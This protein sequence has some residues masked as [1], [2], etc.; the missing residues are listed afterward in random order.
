M[1]RLSIAR[2]AARSA[3]YHWRAHAFTAAAAAVAAAVVTGAL[4]VGDSVRG[5]LADRVLERLGSVEQVL[6]ASGFFREALPGEVAAGA[7][8]AIVLR[9]SAEHAATGSRAS[10]VNV[11]GVPRQFWS[12]WGAPGPPPGLAESWGGRK[13]A[14][15]ERLAAALGAREGDAVL[16]HVR[17]GD[18]VPAEH[19][20]GRRTG[21]VRALR[22]DLERVLPGEGLALFDLRHEQA[23]PR[24]VFVPLDVLQRALEKEGLVNAG[25]FGSSGAPDLLGAEM[26][27]SERL[28]VA[29]RRA[30][31]LED[32]GLKL[33]V[34][35]ERGH[36]SLESR[37]LVLAPP[38][39]EA[40]RGAAREAGLEGR[41]VL[42][43]LANTIAAADRQVPYSTIAAVESIAGRRIEPGTIVLTDW[44]AQDLAAKPGDPV[45]VAYYAVGPEH[46]LEER[47]ALF[48][49]A[50]PVPIEGEAADPGW[51]PEYPGI[52]DARSLR[53]W[54]PPFPMDLG[55]IRDRDEDYW[56]A[57]RTTP[58]AFV[59]LEDGRRLWSS[60]FGDLTAV[61]VR[62]LDPAVPLAE[63]ARA[64]EAALLRA[65]G[66]GAAGLAFQAVKAQGLE[67]ARGSTD[68]GALFLGFS[69]F[70]IASALTILS[71]VFRLACARRSKELGLLAAV[72][73][74][75][76][77][78]RG[79]LLLEGGL[80]VACGS[81]LGAVGG[82][83]YA[84]A[85]VAGL[86]GLWR[87]A[88]SAPFL[89]LHA[90]PGS[91]AAGAAATAA[92]GLLTVLAAARRAS[93]EAPRA[94]LARGG[95]DPG[96]GLRSRPRGT[97]ALAAAAACAAL[98][99]ALLAAGSLPRGL[100]QAPAF[101]G[102]GA[103]LLAAALALAKAWLE[104]PARPLRRGL[105]ALVRLGASYGRRAPG[106]SFA[107]VLLVA[108][109]SFVLVTVAASRRD[110][111]SGG[112]RKGSGDGGFA[113]VAR[114][115]VPFTSSLAA[116]EGREAL[117]LSEEASG[118]LGRAQVHAFRLRP[119]D[120]ASCLNLYRPRSPSVLGAPRSFLERGGFA[121]SRSLAET[122][123]E[124][125]NPWLLLERELPGGA[126]P[127]VGDASTVR[128]ILHAGLGDDIAVADESGGE[129]RL[130]IAGL[131]SHSLFQGELLVSERRFL[132]AFPGT[133][134]YAYLLVEAAPRDAAPLAAALERDLAGHGLDAEPAG[135]VLAGFQ[136]VENTYLATF[137]LLGGLGLLLGTAGLG[138]LLLRNV[139]ERR[140]EL[141]VLR[142]VGYPGGAVALVLVVETA[143]LLALGLAA[144]SG[145]AIVAV[146]PNAA[147]AGSAVSW[148]GIAATLGAILAAGLAA[149]ALA[150]RAALRA[151]LIPA[152]RAE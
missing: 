61:R 37:E 82:L 88:V 60:R 68:F 33:L 146:L 23:A 124:R 91:L 108:S 116:P 31:K 50:A 55:R 44:A 35:A 98:G 134:G 127:A 7:V 65:L 103:L 99:A 149:S 17:R 119:G 13:A 14:G 36:A 10:Q 114:A 75:P 143:S 110:P 34:R 152:L 142:A 42:T 3:A 105:L 126:V 115:S 84:A 57:H 130:R 109:A 32:A 18:E 53:D 95:L 101:F 85:L 8:P 20:L 73:F 70:L 139:E 145:A 41:E 12:F 131:L 151:P 6:L 89:A 26:G 90:A 97:A 11:L 112:P 113:L 25:L 104:R 106:R 2:L 150:V 29:L 38:L 64:F 28:E 133:S 148:G 72:G 96:T 4:L 144:G 66:P 147:S 120:D 121:W 92:L 62:P 100:P 71:L 21:T 22:I 80:V 87:G 79:L 136:A 81:V 138:A 77:T 24:N 86:R 69:L 1:S 58:K 46:R 54:D 49:A 47:E 128:W 129:L 111:A 67:A 51:T 56:D 137:Q 122:A 30:W 59:S 78:L 107:S 48:R 117:S 125:A 9:G 135:E 102:G 45:R 141:A 63:A 16:L 140:A 132:E 74:T 27:R 39:A 19:A 15:S 52:S 123:A 5:S 118:L 94:L 83:G 43:Y 40:A 93:L 76:G